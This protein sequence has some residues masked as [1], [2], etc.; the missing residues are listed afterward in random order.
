MA[1]LLHHAA[2]KLGR[3]VLPIT[4]S[5]GLIVGVPV[6]FVFLL[7][8]FSDGLPY[9]KDANE[10][11]LMYIHAWA[12]YNCNPFSFS[13]LTALDLSPVTRTPTLIYTNNPNLPRYAHYVFFLLGVSS[14]KAQLLAIT[15]TLSA[16]SFWFLYRFFGSSLSILVA[17]PL[18]CD[19]A[20]SQY[21]TNSFRVFC[22]ALFFGCLLSIKSGRFIPLAFFALW[23]L[24]F[25][26]ALFVSVTCGVMFLANYRR[27]LL[28]A[29]SSVLSVTVFVIQVYSYVGWE[30]LVGSVHEAAGRRMFSETAVG[31][32]L[33]PMLSAFYDPYIL[34]CLLFA[35]ILAIHAVAR[36]RSGGM[37]L[38]SRLLL[39]MGCGLVIVLMVLPGYAGDAYF[40]HGLPFV[41]FFLA[42]AFAILSLSLAAAFRLPPV[43]VA[44][45]IMPLLLTNSVRTYARFP[46]LG[47]EYASAISKLGLDG[48]AIDK[49][50]QGAA[51]AGAGAWETF[52]DRQTARE[53]DYYLCL[54]RP[55]FGVDCS[56]RRKDFQRIVVE[57]RN[58]F[59]GTNK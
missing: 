27:W 8:A 15:L 44:L 14:F 26:F 38:L 19:F 51:F 29:A 53:A 28:A 58:F 42:V 24:E 55:W 11:Y 4:C 39:S 37:E 34:L 50:L 2:D 18:L 52:V 30:G 21:L 48:V 1:K 13:F 43:A 20:G 35:V 31:T 22:F 9:F 57:G 25:G 46:A 5:K 17:L 49:P 54:H 23:Q 6:I 40:R 56:E 59:I 47:G 32:E 36:R 16:A 12:L 3:S 45:A 7:W 33:L 10:S 41:T